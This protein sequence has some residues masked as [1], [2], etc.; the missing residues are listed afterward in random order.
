MCSATN[1]NR[2]PCFMQL[3]GELEHGEP[4]VKVGCADWDVADGLTRANSMEVTEQ[5]SSSCMD[6]GHMHMRPPHHIVFVLCFRRGAWETAEP[7]PTTT[8]NDLLGAGGTA[9]IM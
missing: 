5:I 1:T 9:C 3:H 6:V 8:T 2:D 7:G 4:S